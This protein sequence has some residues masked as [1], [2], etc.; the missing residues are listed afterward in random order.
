MCLHVLEPKTLSDAFIIIDFYCICEPSHKFSNWCFRYLFS[1]GRRAFPPPSVRVS[2]RSSRRAATAPRGSSCPLSLAAGSLS[3]PSAR[4]PWCT[5]RKTK[6]IRSGQVKKEEES[7]RRVVP[8]ECS[9]SC[10]VQSCIGPAGA[11]VEP[12]GVVVSS[13]CF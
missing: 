9:G 4:D 11:A 6:E 3:H 1:R 2:S 10:S 13:C 8:G 5:T 12:G 7:M